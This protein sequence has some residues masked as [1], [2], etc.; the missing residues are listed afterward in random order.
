MDSVTGELQRFGKNYETVGTFEEAIKSQCRHEQSPNRN[1]II[2]FNAIKSFEIVDII[3]PFEAKLQAEYKRTCSIPNCH[4][5][6][7]TQWK[8]PK[9]G[10]IEHYIYTDCIARIKELV[11]IIQEGNYSEKYQKGRA[12]LSLETTSKRDKTDIRR[13][14]RNMT[15]YKKIQKEYK[16]LC[17]YIDNSFV[18][19]LWPIN[20]FDRRKCLDR[21]K[22]KEK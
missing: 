1:V 2:R 7:T 18:A 4:K 16:R 8:H 19:T 9:Y 10:I 14:L 6:V 21:F 3:K 20:Y 15:E 17:R 12:Y 11:K 5:K 22:I 13:G